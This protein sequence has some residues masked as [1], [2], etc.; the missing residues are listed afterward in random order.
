M[1]TFLD[2]PPTDRVGRY[3]S[4]KFQVKSLAYTAQPF[5]MARVLPGETLNSLYLESRVVTDPVL[6]SIIGWKKQY[7]FF[8]V[9]ITDLLVDAMKDMFIDPTNADIGGTYG[10][11]AQVQWT[12]TAKG[13]VDWLDKGMT[14]IIDE[15]FRDDGETMD[16]YVS[17]VMSGVPFVQYRD[18]GWLDNLTDKDDLPEGDAISGAT[19][20]GDLDRLMDAFE[21]LRAMGIANMSYE[22]WLRSQGIAIPGESEH[23]PEMLGSFSEFMYPSNTIDPSDG[24]ATSAVSWVFKNSLRSPKFFKEPG[25]IIGLSITRPKVYFAGVA[26]ALAGFAT[27]AWDWMPNYMAQMPET[28]LK[29]FAGDAG[30]LGDRTTPTDDYWVDMCDDLIHGDQFQNMSTWG[31]GIAANYAQHRMP[32]PATDLT[33]KYPDDDDAKGFFVDAA[34]TA[35]YVKQD[36]VCKLSIKGKQVDYTQGNFAVE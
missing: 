22:D 17:S 25:F 13:G 1:R 29:Q 36:G 15:Y 16:D 9:R 14:R 23:K 21:Q 26:G 7:F 27:R 8:Y 30:P 19:D 18:T 3:P 5:L 12:N 4:H 6:N 31:P 35:F 2:A 10:E 32:G 34:G 33:F 28:R 24:S 11:A 20:A